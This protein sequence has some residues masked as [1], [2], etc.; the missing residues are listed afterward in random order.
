MSDRDEKGKEVTDR[1]SARFGSDETD[2]TDEGSE[3]DHR[4]KPSK[5]SKQSE[6]DKQEQRSE[7]AQSDEQDENDK[8]SQLSE[9]VQSDENVDTDENSGNDLNVKEDWMG[10]YMY[11]PP[12]IHKRFDDEYERLRY[13][14][15]RDLD[16]KPKK[17]KHYYP[18]VAVNGIDA[19][20]NMSP[21]DFAD[22][23]TDL[24]WFDDTQD[25]LTS[26]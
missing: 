9:P 25:S 21:T 2:K 11:I 20:A 19:V 16:W 17:N 10:R 22:A 26:D 3:Q 13:E 15:G 1:L 14:C 5:H 18:V 8:Q 4:S 7:P 23:I 6:S 12:G 24:E